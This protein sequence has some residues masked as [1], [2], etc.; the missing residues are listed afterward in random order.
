MSNNIIE[1]TKLGEELISQL[2][3]GVHVITQKVELMNIEFTEKTNYI[4]GV[5]KCI[6]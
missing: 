2:R 3:K 4:D 1:G 6:F 5:I